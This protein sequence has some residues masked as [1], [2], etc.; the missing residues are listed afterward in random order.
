MPASAGYF[1]GAKT[2]TLKGSSY[3]NKAREARA[4]IHQFSVLIGMR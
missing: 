3:T 2:Y 4:K 1:Y